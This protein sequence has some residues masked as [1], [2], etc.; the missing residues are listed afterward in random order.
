[1]FN[2]NDRPSPLIEYDCEATAVKIDPVSGYFIN[3]SD[4]RWREYPQLEGKCTAIRDFTSGLLTSTPGITYLD[5]SGTTLYAQ[6]LIDACSSDL[7]TNLF[8][9]PHS[10]AAS[11]QLTSCRVEDIRRRVLQFF[12]GSANEWDVVFVANATAAIKLV[13][14]AF[15]DQ[16][17]GFDLGYHEECHNSVVGLRQVAQHSQ[18]VK[19]TQ[20]FD[21][22]LRSRI[23][24]SHLRRRP[25]RPKLIALPGQS[26][27]SGV[28]DNALLTAVCQKVKHE[29]SRGRSVYSLLDAAALASTAPVDLAK[30]CYRHDYISL[31]FYKIFGLPDLGALLVKKGPAADILLAKRYFAGG[32]VDLVI[33]GSDPYHIRHS[34]VHEA[35]EEGTIPFHNILVL[36]HALDVHTRIYGSMQN[37]TRHV[38][39]ITNSAR[40]QMLALRHKTGAPVV[41]VYWSS[42]PESQ[43]PV[44]AFSVLDAAGHH[45]RASDVEL[46]A[47]DAK[48]HLRKGGMCNPGGVAK[49][50]DITAKQMRDFYA[51]G[52]K[53]SDDSR[54]PPGFYGAVGIIRVSFGAMSSTEDVEALTKWLRE[55]FVNREADSLSYEDGREDTTS[56]TAFDGEGERKSEKETVTKL[57]V[58]PGPRPRA[59]RRI[60]SCF[61]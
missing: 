6:S 54:A 46:S 45:F 39:C 15:R 8:G 24:F 1:M 22:W 28:R 20:T 50:L 43:G 48:I 41:R 4:I 56:S 14:E 37:I 33:P 35:L 7:K 23:R 44:I 17:S 42:E 61:R 47:I 32:T 19:D 2:V 12:N 57:E 59:L 3:I 34:N 11:S 5:H 27:L 9:N 30:S 51:R 60:L 13:G 21:D 26:N 53:C 10:G 16:P 55:T 31:S 18:V 29:Q 49:Y 58:G 40:E 38:R 52:I 36:G 25:E